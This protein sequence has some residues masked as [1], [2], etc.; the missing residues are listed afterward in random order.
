MAMTD[1]NTNPKF[2]TFKRTLDKDIF[3][4]PSKE[5]DI[6]VEHPAHLNEAIN[7]GKVII[8]NYPPNEQ[9]EMFLMIRDIIIDNRKFQMESLQKEIELLRDSY[10]RLVQ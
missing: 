6:K 2:G 1:L 9:N 7:M 10:E 3:Q 5:E 4:S 8:S